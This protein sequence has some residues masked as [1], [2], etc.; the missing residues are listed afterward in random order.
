MVEKVWS[1]SS[2]NVPILL[3]FRLMSHD[4]S[5][6]KVLYFNILYGP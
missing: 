6:V 2:V 4:K 1:E 5:V 3:F